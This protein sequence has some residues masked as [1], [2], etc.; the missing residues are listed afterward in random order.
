MAIEVSGNGAGHD[1]ADPNAAGAQVE[2]HGLCESYQSELAGIVGAAT[3]KEVGARQARDGEDVA[4]G[5]LQQWQCC[6]DA[7]KNACQ[8]GVDGLVPLLKRDLIDGRE[9]AYTGISHQY[10]DATEGFFGCRY[11]CL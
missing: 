2:H 6:P 3:G 4:P 8:V 1:G 7:V 5:Y 10:I 9:M 11:G